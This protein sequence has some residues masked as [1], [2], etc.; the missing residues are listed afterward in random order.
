MLQVGSSYYYGKNYIF[1]VI[2]IEDGADTALSQ[3][4]EG[5]LAHKWGLAAYLPTD[6]PYKSTAPTI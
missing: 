5:Y 1:E 6:H 4:I 2:V 3:I